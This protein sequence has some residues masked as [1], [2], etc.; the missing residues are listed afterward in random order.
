ML[1]LMI[2]PDLLSGTDYYI[3]EMISQGEA[4]VFVY[5]SKGSW[6]WLILLGIGVTAAVIKSRKKKKSKRSAYVV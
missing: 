5:P 4:P 6:L 2:Q 3:I 1:P